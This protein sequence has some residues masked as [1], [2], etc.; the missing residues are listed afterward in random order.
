MSTSRTCG[1]PALLIAAGLALA[2]CGTA[3]GAGTPVQVARV[4]TPQEGQPGVITLAEAAAQRL[5]MQTTAVAAGPNGLTVPYGALVYEADGSAWVFVQTAPLT[6]QRAPVVV[7]GI[8]GD[9]VTLVSGPAAGTDVVTV[10]AA[11]LVGVE[12]GIDGEE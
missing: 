6:Y 3:E 12:T 8:S 7:A 4:E 11:E 10:G 1:I 2:G 5:G 9:Q